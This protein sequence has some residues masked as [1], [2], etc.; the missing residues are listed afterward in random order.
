MRF[1]G[2]FIRRATTTTLI[3]AAI[4]GF[5]AAQLFFSARQQPA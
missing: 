5:G 1:T 3:I 4:A 2:F